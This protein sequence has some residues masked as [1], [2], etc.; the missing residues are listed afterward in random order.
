VRT[1]V[2]AT[3]THPHTHTHTHT[4]ARART[5][6]AQGQL[7]EAQRKR[8]GYDARRRAMVARAGRVTEAAVEKAQAAAA[9][10]PSKGV[11]PAPAAAPAAAPAPAAAARDQ[12]LVQLAEDAAAANSECGSWWCAF[13]CGGV[14][15]PGVCVCVCVCVSVGLLRLQQPAGRPRMLAGRPTW[16]LNMVRQ[17]RSPRAPHIDP[18]PLCPPP[19]PPPHTHTAQ[20][21]EFESEVEALDDM[22][23]WLVGGAAR[24]KAL[25]ADAAG[26]VGAAAAGWAPPAGLLPPFPEKS[27]IG[28]V[29]IWRRVCRRSCR[30]RMHAH[31]HTMRALCGGC[32]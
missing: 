25:V 13:V 30:V 31:T 10:P 9:S 7:A 21:A 2:H 4:R 19:P 23:R 1:C 14:A 8:L 12:G 6:H 27:V 32:P 17:A 28:P 26:G 18:P 11:P 3:P 20:L 29:S 5:S 16:E 22:L 15:A 24:I